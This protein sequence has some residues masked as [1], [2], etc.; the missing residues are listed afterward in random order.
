MCMST[1]LNTNNISE[2]SGSNAPN[3]LIIG[4][5]HKV[6]DPDRLGLPL[7]HRFIMGEGKLCSQFLSAFI[8]FFYDRIFL[9]LEG[10][11]HKV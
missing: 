8:I 7:S 11:D 4:G 10:N 3:F 2:T 9:I 6:F 5:L 1:L